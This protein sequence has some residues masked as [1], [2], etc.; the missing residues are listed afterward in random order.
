MQVLYEDNHLLAVVKPPGVATMGTPQGVETLL[1]RAKAYLARKYKKTGNVYLGVVSRLDA[2]VTG[3]VLMARTSK[4][5]ARLSAA[6]RDREVGKQYLALVEGRAEPPEAR[7]EHYL[8]KDERHRKVH[9]TNSEAD[10]ATRAEL[11]YETLLNRGEH[12]LLLVK[13]VTGR[14]HQIRVQLAKVGHPIVGDRKYGS[15]TPLKQGIRLHAWRLTIE[16]PVRRE[17]MTIKCPL[18]KGWPEW[19]QHAA[20]KL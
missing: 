5:A 20:D 15:D 1:D 10:D 13:P 8:R 14:K 4:A 3:V 9:V 17:K 11:S 2:P 12:T 6:F 18:P 19:A 7:L 16:H